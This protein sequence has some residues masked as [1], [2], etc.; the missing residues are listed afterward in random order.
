M[1]HKLDGKVD[2][3]VHKVSTKDTLDGISIRYNVSKRKI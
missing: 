3:V 2:Y 1:E